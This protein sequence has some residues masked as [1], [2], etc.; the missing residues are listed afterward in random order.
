M[1]WISKI[2]NPHPKA[3][4]SQSDE[5]SIILNI[6]DE[7]KTTNKFYVDIGA[8]A[9]GAAMSNTQCLD[10]E[11]WRGLAFDMD[12]DPTN[13]VK[14]E[15]ITPFN[16][17]DVLK[18]YDCPKNFDFL[19]LDIDSSDYDVLESILENYEPRV[20]C[21]E[22]N[23]TLDPT[24]TIKMEYEEGY[25]WDKTNRYG[26]SFGAGKYLLEKNGY[27]IILNQGETN[28]FAIKKELITFEMEEVQATKSMYHKYNES[29][30]WVD[31]REPI[32]KELT[33][34]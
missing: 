33:N 11:V 18:K 3:G 14:K 31:C 4:F 16:V 27:T 2:R 19:S 13:R 26:Y 20:I 28:L 22:F 29:A 7:I 34:D 5:D 25:V 15:F 12:F 30:K 6:F 23:G 24:E 10:N 21:T 32:K 1:N 9:Y 8:L 17:C